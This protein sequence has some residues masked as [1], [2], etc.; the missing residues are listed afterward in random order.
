M[1]ALTDLTPDLGSVV[2]DRSQRSFGQYL[3]ENV[4]RRNG[5]LLAFVVVIIFLAIWQDKFLSP[6]NLT[7]LILQ[8]SYILILALGMLMVIVLAQIDL[9]VGSVVAFTGAVAAVVVLRMH[10]PWW[11]GVL[12]AVICGILVG[13]WQGFWVAVVGIPG[14]V[15]T[16]GGQLIFRGLAQ[17]VL[18]YNSLSP[19]GGRYYQISNG[20]IKGVFG[21]QEFDVF[22]VVI[23]A[24]AV[25]GLVVA[26]IRSR[27]ARLKYKQSVA[28]LPLFV[29]QLVLIGGVAMFFGFQI[30]QNRG[31]PVILIILAVFIMVYGIVMG[32]TSFG[33]SIYAIGGNLLAAQLSGVKTKWITF[34]AFVNMGFL[35]GV[36]G[37]IFSARMNGAQPAAG[38]G[39]ELDAIAACFI[40]G[41]STTGGIGRIAGA[42]IGGLIMAVI[43]NGMQ[44]AGL[45]QGLQPIIKG[46]ILTLAVAFDLWNKRRTSVA[47]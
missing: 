23:F 26:Q 2:A 32:R 30:S 27:A 46:L 38:V 37:V 39:M 5:I 11:V 47:A 16:L 34:W 6:P 18:N 9:S 14:F 19:F 29:A 28:P 8:Y 17:L 1:S 15:V 20:F 25:V 10:M 22:T 7:N 43:S 42:M 41:A 40:G 36:A 21:G 24:I 3:L 4:V 45:S 13:V 31:L 44:L 35:A 12:A 33:R